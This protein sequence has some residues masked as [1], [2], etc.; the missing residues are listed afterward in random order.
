M[1][2]LARVFASTKLQNQ[3]P[4]PFNKGHIDKM[5]KPLYEFFPDLDREPDKKSATWSPKVETR[6][7]NGEPNIRF[8]RRI[9]R[10]RPE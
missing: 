7:D 4:P 5:E 9:P 10:R 3:T 8:K 1:P 2:V 6:K